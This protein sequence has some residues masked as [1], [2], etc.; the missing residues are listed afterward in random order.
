MENIVGRTKEKTI[1]EKAY[2]SPKSEFVAVY[3]RRRVGKTFLIR[4]TFLENTTFHLTGLNNAN[5]RQQLVN[6]HT[7]LTKQTKADFSIPKNWFDAF[8][9]LI[10]VV[11]NSNDPKKVVFL[12][13]LPW[14]DTPK[15]D[16]LI[17]LEH[18]WNSWASA[19]KDILLIV[20]GSSASWVL[21][22]LINNKGGL[23]NRVTVRIKLEPF[24]LSECEVFF[25]AKS[26][27]F[28]RYQL[29]ELYMVF[30]GIPFYLDQVDVQLSAVQNI[31][32][33]CFEEN[34]FFRIEYKNLYDSLFKNADNHVAVVEALAQKAKGLKRNDLAK[35]SKLAN[36]GT[37]T[38]ILQE[39]EDSGFIRKYVSFGKKTNEAIYQL[40]DFYSIF[41]LKFIRNSDVL[42]ERFWLNNIDSPHRRAWSGYAFERVCLSHIREIKQALGVGMIQTAV[43]AWQNEDTQIDLL[44]DRRDQVINL[45]ELKFS[46]NPF[47]ID[48]KYAENLGNKISTFKEAT[49]TRKAIY[50]TMIT[51]FGLVKNDY[52][53]SMVQNELTMDC[54]FFG[55]G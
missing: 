4:Q 14:L 33:L 15:S 43:S 26:S 8:Q 36:G 51:T 31:N 11:E 25:K 46:I 27:A 18:F 22:K 53:S 45:C 32:N 52:A 34:S 30:G 50:L 54:L 3:G 19:R 37:F 49:Q 39:L 1:L 55:V 35:A 17:A 12:D 9:Q 21:N 13:E 44:I 40:N 42:D 5:L 10:A 38:K 6:F 23:H 20:C 29:L 7:A 24:N 28:T 41:Y 2:N 48:K 47:T 16:F